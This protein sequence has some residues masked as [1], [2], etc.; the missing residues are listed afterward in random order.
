MHMQ[1][2]TYYCRVT[3]FRGYKILWIVGNL[4]IFED[5][6]DSIVATYYRAENFE[7]KYFRG[8]VFIHE[9]LENFYPQNPTV[10]SSGRCA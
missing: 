9:I 2:S 1:C 6:S 3:Y 8:F 5:E 7:D 4:K 10:C